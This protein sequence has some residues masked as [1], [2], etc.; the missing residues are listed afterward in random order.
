MN[1]GFDVLLHDSN[2]IGDNCRCRILLFHFR[3]KFLV[4]R[5]T[6]DSRCVMLPH[7]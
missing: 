2:T 6:D 7:G 4:I 5:N 1:S 3:P